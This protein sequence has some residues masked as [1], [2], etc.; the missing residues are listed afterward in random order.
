MGHLASM[1]RASGVELVALC[2]MDEA[3]LQAAGQRYGVRALYSDMGAMIRE[4]DADLVSII[5]PPTLR[6]SVVKPAIEAGA[7]A[8]LIEKPLALS[9]SESRHL[10]ELGRG[11]LIAVNTQYGWMPHWK[12]LWP[13]LAAGELGEIHTIRASTRANILEQG[14][15]ILALALEA[16]RLAGL[17]KPEWVLAA[18]SGLEFFGDTP[19]PADTTAIIGLAQARLH[20][21][22]GLSAPFVPG[23]DTFYL[24]IQ[25]EVVGS[26]G[27]FQASLTKGWRLETE[28]GVE[29]GE[30]GWPAGDEAAQPALF[31]E[32]RV[33]LLD[34]SWHEFPTRVE[35]A[36][37]QTQLLFGCYA[38]MIERRKVTLDREFGDEVVE[39]LR[40]L[41]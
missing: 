32:L 33:R 40:V 9:P 16:A 14:P 24:S 29:S 30:T 41:G 17:P 37:E 19:V 18:G 4:A 13:R 27:R 3:K 36:N 20:L 15:H 6:L 1:E 35:V 2:E 11:R 22:C 8:I 7:R 23:E 25:V 5:T 34:G 26:R 38:S 10:A 39:G 31:E 28:S 12:M 21:D